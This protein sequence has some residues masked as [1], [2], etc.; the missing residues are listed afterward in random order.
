MKIASYI[1]AIV[2]ISSGLA[3]AKLERALFEGHLKDEHY[4]IEFKFAPMPPF[5]NYPDAPKYW[6]ILSALDVQIGKQSI[7]VPKAAYKDLF[8][9]HSP[10]DP[11]YDPHGNIR[12]PLKGGDGEKSYTVDFIFRNGRLIARDY[13]PHMST[14][15][16]T[17]HYQ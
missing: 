11:F 10:S 8:A 7:K 9:P 13:Y 12:L 14:K 16:I 5:P 4:L 17:T 15:P 3:S 1:L 2:F 6:M